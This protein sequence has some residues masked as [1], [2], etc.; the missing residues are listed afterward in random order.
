M[1]KIRFIAFFC[2]TVI[3]LLSG[4]SL[5]AN[6]EGYIKW[7]DCNVPYE[8]LLNAYEYD[9]KYY[10]SEEVQFDFA[11]ALAYLAVKN[12]NKYQV[13][14]D[15]KA[16]SD[17]VHKLKEGKKISDFYGDNKYYIYY[18]ESYR[19]IFAQFIGEY[20]VNDTRQYGLKN[21]HPFP[22]GYWYNHYDDFG[23][24]RSYGFK[25]KHLGH[26][27]M[28]SIGTPMIAIEGGTV[29]E[30]GWNKY[31][32]WR[33][34]IR[35]F[36]GKRSYYY[37]HLRKNKPYAEGV[38]KGSTIEA[39]QVI[40]YLGV[41]G[42]SRKEN[43]NMGCPPHLHLGMQLIFDESQYSGRGEIWIDMYHITKFLSHNRVEVKKGETDYYSVNVKKTI[44]A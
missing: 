5:K 15:L 42:Y 23:A 33:I 19:A 34:G 10:G 28:G 2:V 27:L 24:S 35:S 11:E 36:D 20:S 17:L 26:D 3:V 43:A 37:A 13:K 38:Q 8:I 30:F 16:L 32:G 7:V 29:T 41:T 25:R 14:K 12:G 44:S 9:V 4:Y 22:K 18:V 39:G 21:Y 40:G 6:A 1:K 31:G